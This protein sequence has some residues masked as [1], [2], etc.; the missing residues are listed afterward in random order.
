MS[1][2]EDVID[3]LAD[4]IEEVA[5]DYEISELNIINML[6]NETQA[7]LELSGKYNT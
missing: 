1:N 7:R 3:G 2:L 5:D 4:Q 6:L